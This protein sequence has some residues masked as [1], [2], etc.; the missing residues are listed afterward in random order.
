MRTLLID[1][2]SLIYA[3]ASSNETATQWD[4]DVWTYH[5]DF[6]AARSQLDFNIESMRKRLK[7]DVCVL[8]LSNNNNPWRKLV[9]PTYKSN[10]KDTRKPVLLKPLRDYVH[11]EYATFERPGL[12]GD[13]VLGILLTAP[14]PPEPVVGERILCSIDKDMSTL[15]GLHFNWMKDRGN[16]GSP[17]VREVSPVEADRFHMLQALTGDRVDGYAGCKGIGP[18]KAE[19]ILD[20]LE[21]VE[22][23]WPRVVETFVSKGF[24][25][26]DALVQARVSRICRVTD[27]NFKTKEVILWKPPA[28]APAS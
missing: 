13:D 15:P 22:Q 19:K 10:R 14:K 12:E 27:F 24:S 1:A 28:P 3:A 26:E 6:D 11:E 2:D 9:L 21:T 4:Q 17:V 18:K 8:A 20:G 23:M 7:A 5:G 16:T 25:E